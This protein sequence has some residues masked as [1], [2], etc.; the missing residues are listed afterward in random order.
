MKYRYAKTSCDVMVSGRSELSGM[1]L[2]ATFDIYIYI[3]I[4]NA[5]KR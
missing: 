3:E 2:V 1:N 5:L 4:H